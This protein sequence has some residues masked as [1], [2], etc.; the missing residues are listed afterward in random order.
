MKL[1]R[2]EWLQAM[3]GIGALGYAGGLSGLLRAASSTSLVTDRYFVFAYFSGGWDGLLAL[4]PRDPD[5][6]T[7]A[8]VA[9]TGIQTGYGLLDLEDL[10]VPTSVDSMTFGPFIGNLATHAEK[11]VVLRG[12]AMS[13][14]AHDPARKH[15]LTGF[16]PAGTSARR[17]SVATLLASLLGGNEP[18]PNLAVGVDSFNL[19]LP[20]WAS[21]L[22]AGDIDDLFKALTPVEVDL[23]DSQRDALEDFFAKQ[24]ERAT[25]QIESSIYG[26][27]VIA[28]SLIEQDLAQHFDIDSSDA[29]MVELRARYG[30]DS[31]EGGDGGKMALLASQALTQGVSR[32]VSIRVAE[33]LDSHQ[34]FEWRVEHGANL[35]EGFNAIAA[36]AED[37]DQ[38]PF[39]DTGDSWLDHTTICCFSEFGRGSMLN[40][41]GGRDHSLIN[42]MLL[43]GGGIA[44]G[45]VIGAST[46]TGMQ[47]Q[48]VNLQ[49][50][51]LSTS[52][53]L[54]S[55]DH[56]ARSLLSSVGV[57]DDV[58]DFRAD[59]ITAMLTEST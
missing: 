20:L 46:D 25:T 16:M 43:L 29:T 17:S 11:L 27:Q 24:L 30:I 58:G 12:M 3:T 7:P 50:G 41:A 13:A 54:L 4:D 15:A 42:A 6:F 47:A 28:R 37:L 10:L 51:Q 5:I 33:G 59:P 55:Y 32:C 52:G 57:V 31:G 49:T 40:N 53:E 34:G 44:G 45:Q 21:G 38:R 2:R 8:E 19:G 18:I 48:A 26:N 56:V 1:T 23:L 9:N 14:V 39:G 36:L 22:P 35:T